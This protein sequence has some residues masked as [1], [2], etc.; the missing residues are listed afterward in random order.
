MRTTS[1]AAQKLSSGGLAW[2]W[3]NV[4]NCPRFV[5]LIGTI[6]TFTGMANTIGG[7]AKTQLLEM[8]DPIFGLPFR[9]LMLLLGASQLT[10]VFLCLFTNKQILGLG[11]AAWLSANFIFYR[12]GLLTMG[13]HHSCG[14]LIAPLGFSLSA[15]DVI[16]SLSSVLVL[17]ASTSVLWIEL[18]TCLTAEF[19]KTACP[20]CGTHLR[21]AVRNLGRQVSCPSCKTTIILRQPDENLKMT[22]ILCGG[23]VEF[24]PHALGRKIQCPHCAKTITLLRPA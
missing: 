5:L 7:L 13:W 14:F 23:H 19:L 20:S 22:C 18:R 12:I 1:I 9:C 21:F 3:L 10:C 2:S 4:F 6:L 17:T 8:P 24:P 16:L 15:T 11:L